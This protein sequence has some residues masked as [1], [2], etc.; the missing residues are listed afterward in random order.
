MEKDLNELQTLIEAHFENRKKEEQ[1]L[2]SLKDRIVGVGRL[3]GP[4]VV[5][6]EP[7]G[8]QHPP[9][10]GLE[11][12]HHLCPPPRSPRAPPPAPPL[13]EGRCGDLRDPKTFSG[14]QEAV[15][16]P[17]S[18]LLPCCLADG[19]TWPLPPAQGSGRGG[20]DTQ[21]TRRSPPTLF[22]R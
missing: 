22:R 13:T 6:Q 12:S 8:P 1:E 18:P 9:P 20:G 10:R 19:R 21:G 4:G 15:R 14:G 2:I 7:L 16:L 5:Q 11:P 3:P 17:F